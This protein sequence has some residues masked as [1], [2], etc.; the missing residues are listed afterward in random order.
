[1]S[2]PNGFYYNSFLI[3]I[4]NELVKDEDI[5]DVDNYDEKLHIY[6]EDF[7]YC[8][9]DKAKDLILRYGV[10]KAIGLYEV[11]FDNYKLKDTDNENYSLLAYIII[12]GWFYDN[13]NCD[14]FLIEKKIKRSEKDI[15]FDI[16]TTPFKMPEII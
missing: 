5:I 3:D 9:T 15:E 4:I 7:V 11:Y 2:Y 16:L 12:K 1:M 10:F 6:I 8:Y 13:Y 14:K